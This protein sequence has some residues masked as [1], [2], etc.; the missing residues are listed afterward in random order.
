MSEATGGQPSLALFDQPAQMQNPYY[1]A[2][3]RVH[4]MAPDQMREHDAARWPGGC[5]AGF[6]LWNSKRWREWL[7]VRGITG[8]SLIDTE[9]QA[10][11][12]AWLEAIETA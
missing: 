2:Y 1:L 6:V 11:Y 9:M 3:A 8:D 7:N 4:G 5:M 12:G 10:D